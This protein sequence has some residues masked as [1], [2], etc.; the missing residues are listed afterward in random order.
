MAMASEDS[1]EYCD[2]LMRSPGRPINV[3]PNNNAVYSPVSSLH[4]LSLRAAADIARM[5][6]SDQTAATV[7]GH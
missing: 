4:L 2:L 5:H 3:T 7:Y 6:S 1:L